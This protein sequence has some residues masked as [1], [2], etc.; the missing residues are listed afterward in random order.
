MLAFK[1]SV[2]N[3]LYNASLQFGENWRK[4]I[5]E[6]AEELYPNMP[7]IEQKEL[8]CYIKDTRDNIEKYIY[9]GYYNT[10]K[11]DTEMLRKKTSLYI[12]NEYP[13]MNSYNVEHAI[14][15]GIYYAWRG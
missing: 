3:D 12:E 6:L 13:W 9:D 5:I 4:P 11:D 15:Q 7:P 8:A 1:D 2:L 10:Y 14:S